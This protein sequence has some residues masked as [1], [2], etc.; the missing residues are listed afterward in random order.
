MDFAQLVKGYGRDDNPELERRYSPSSTVNSTMRQVSG[1]P[2]PKH[3]ST[4]YVER[5]NLS[6]WM[7]VRRFARMTNAY[8]KRLINHAHHVAL[9]AV[10]YNFCRIPLGTAMSPA[11]QAGV[12][13][14][15]RDLGWIVDL[16]E[17]NT[18]PPGPRGPY[19]RRAR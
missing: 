17:I 7:S 4:S 3:V 12:A 18:P 6:V 9:Y 13:G 15:L 5:H 19:R 16:I 14:E 11:M 2:D 8:S 1:R 10:W